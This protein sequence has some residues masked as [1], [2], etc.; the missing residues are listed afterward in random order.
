MCQGVYDSFN[1]L[2]VEHP[3]H[4]MDASNGRGSEHGKGSRS[5]VEIA[6]SITT[7]AT[8]RDSDGYSVPVRHCG[9]G[10]ATNRVVVRIRRGARKSI[11]HLVGCSRDEVARAVHYAASTDIRKEEGRVSG[12]HFTLQLAG[13]NF[14][15]RSVAYGPTPDRS[16]QGY[17]GEQLHYEHSPAK[18]FSEMV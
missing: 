2:I 8:I 9:D 4:P 12:E 5:E 11:E 17:N 6:Q 14:K 1:A 18:A 10:F 16:R 7:P 13:C 15:L 3:I